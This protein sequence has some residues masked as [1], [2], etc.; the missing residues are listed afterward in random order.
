MVVLIGYGNSLRRDDGA[1]P[2]LARLAE[3]WGGRGD[4]KVITP[5]QLVPEL[6]E[7]LAEA[8]VVAV[9]FLDASAHDSRGSE[10]VAIR[11]VGGEARSPAFGHHFSPAVL[12]RYAELLRGGP[13]PAWQIT[14]PGIDFGH[15]E[16]L[17]GYSEQLLAVAFKKL[18]IFLRKIPLQ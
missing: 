6:A 16:G 1:G 13:L 11:P 18:Q 14:I 5:H 10:R 17:S 7:D 15:G 4:L 12:L 3:A 9:L 8:G 2:A